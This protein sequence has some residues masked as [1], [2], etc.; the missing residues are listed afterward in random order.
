MTKVI[1]DISMSL[2]GFVTGPDPGLANGLGTGGEPLHT[3]AFSGDEVDANVL[4][5]A[6]ERSGAVIM[7]RR[8]FDIIDG[9][10]G[11]DDEV[12]YGAGLAGTPPFFVVTHSAPDDARLGLDFTFVTDGIRAAVDLARLAAGAKDVVVMGGGDVVRQCV[13]EGLVD[14]LHIHLAPI[15]LG[16]GTPLFARSGRHELLQRSVRV[17]RHATHLSYDVV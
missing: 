11:W 4:R 14:E 8:L 5:A 15:V 10:H 13:D 2:D 3:W 7:G 6:T 16:A 17:S 1:A 9:P 12:G